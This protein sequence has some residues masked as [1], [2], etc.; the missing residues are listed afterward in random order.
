MSRW[1]RSNFLVAMA[2][3]HPKGDVR[4][5]PQAP[6]TKGPTAGRWWVRTVSQ[7]ESSLRASTT[8]C[9]AREAYR[10]ARDGGDAHLDVESPPND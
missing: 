9:H 3:M 7:G 2:P 4:S 8:G 1:R 6:Y 10:T 5:Y